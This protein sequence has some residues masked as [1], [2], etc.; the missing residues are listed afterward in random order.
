MSGADALSFSLVTLDELWPALTNQPIGDADLRLR[1]ASARLSAPIE[2]TGVPPLVVRFNA[3]AELSLFVLNGRTGSDVDDVVEASPGDAWVKYEC[4]ADVAVDARAP[5]GPATFAGRKSGGVTFA[6]YRRHP[7]ETG[8][9]TAVAGDLVNQRVP[10]VR[11]HVLSMAAK[12]A[13]AF[14]TRGELTASVAVEWSDIFT[15]E[16]AALTRLLDAGGPIAIQTD[17]GLACSAKV[18]VTDTFLVAFARAAADD[19]SLRVAI[20]KGD[21]HKADVGAGVSIDVAFDDRHALE[22][23]VDGV[24]EKLGIDDTPGGEKVADVRARAMD[25]IEKV[26]RT[27]IGAAFAYEYHRVE[28]TV[29]LFEATIAAGRL[30]PRLHAALVCG[31]IADA[32]SAPPSAL[33]VSRYLNDRRTTMTRAWGF[34]LG[35]GKWQMFGRDRRRLTR[36]V[37]YDVARKVESRSYIGSGGY[38]RTHLTWMVDFKADMRGW[39]AVPLVTDYD[40]GLHLAWTRDRQ[41]FDAGDLDTALDFAALW[42]IC[43][44]RSLPWL[45]DRLSPFVG[46]DAEWSF[47]VRLG[48]TALRRVIEAIAAM[49]PVDFGAVA[50]AAMDAGVGRRP[51]SARRALFAPLWRAVL[52]GPDRFNVDAVTRFAD[53]AVSDPQAAWR[54]GQVA[55]A[56]TV[57]PD[58]VAG[59]V[60]SNPGMFADSERLVRGCRSL[61]DA[62][63][64]SRRDDGVVEEVYADLAPFWSESHQVRMLGALVTDVAPDLDR[65]DRALRISSAA[66]ATVI[67]SRD[68]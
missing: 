51:P 62:L 17:V 12:D 42:K 1:V 44:E 21:V 11:E 25:A 37:R 68:S 32:L 64:A 13:L 58:T 8:L 27:K 26:A 55:K 18:T 61:V 5:V 48:D 39:A 45:R 60:L 40:F 67:S 41:T 4:D 31:D 52:A 34:T 33:D 57:S 2:I 19:G 6:D 65:V 43:P 9:A 23:V 47:H 14:E 59:V 15:S 20:R 54:E 53:V 10:L 16:I 29:A 49:A 50:A 66:G 30:S 38:E 28:S 36:V 63:G 3:G 24:I 46:V 22:R 56:R 7:P 35:I